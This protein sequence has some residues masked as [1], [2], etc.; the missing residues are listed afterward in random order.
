MYAVVKC[1][2]KER[3]RRGI[4]L[5]DRIPPVGLKCLS[6]KR[7]EEMATLS[8][9]EHATGY[10]FSA[11]ATTYTYSNSSR[12]VLATSCRVAGGI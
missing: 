5:V 12:P 4:A 9:G 7:R 10:G 8:G 6:G 2:V 1:K 3:P 11:G